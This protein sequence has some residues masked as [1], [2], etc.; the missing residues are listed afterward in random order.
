MQRA[1]CGREDRS[2]A[3]GSSCCELPAMHSVPKSAVLPYASGVGGL[4][5]RL[6]NPA[7]PSW[8]SADARLKLCFIRGDARA[9]DPCQEIG[10]GGQKL[11]RFLSAFAPATEGLGQIFSGQHHQHNWAFVMDHH[12]CGVNR[13]IGAQISPM[14][15][16]M[17]ACWG[18]LEP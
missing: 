3:L 9:A 8:S 12:I 16:M 7:W 10:F 15:L 4:S 14:M 1:G 6:L 18:L 5:R 13:E 11:R 2:A 17:L